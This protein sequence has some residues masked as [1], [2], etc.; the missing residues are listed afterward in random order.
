MAR[1]A[2]CYRTTEFDHHEVGHVFFEYTSLSEQYL[3]V[4]KLM[5]QHDGDFIVILGSDGE[6]ITSVE[7]HNVSS[8]FYI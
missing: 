6:P 4:Q 2:I 5:S 8:P 3:I 1:Q 7:K